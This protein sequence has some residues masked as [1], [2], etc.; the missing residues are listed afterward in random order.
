MLRLFGAYENVSR[1][2]AHSEIQLGITLRQK[3]GLSD[4]RGDCVGLGSPRKIAGPDFA[5]GY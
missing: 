5:L 2:G 4:L 3:Q 1:L